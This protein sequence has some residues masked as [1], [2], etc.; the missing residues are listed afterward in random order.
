MRQFYSDFYCF[1]RVFG[2]G[3]FLNGFPN[4]V[5]AHSRPSFLFELNFYFSLVVFFVHM[6]NFDIYFLFFFLI[7]YLIFFKRFSQFTHSPSGS[8]FCF[9]NENSLNCTSG[10]VLLCFFNSSSPSMILTT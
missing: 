7:F 10:L 8:F 1:F 9:V 6:R 4:P 3:F 2:S 5:T